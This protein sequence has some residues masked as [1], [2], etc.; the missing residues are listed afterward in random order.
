VRLS[1]T[2]LATL[3]AA[4]TTRPLAV[5]ATSPPDPQ[6]NPFGRY[7]TDP[8]GTLAGA[9]GRVLDVAAAAGHRLWLPLAAVLLAGVAGR[10]V[11][12]R[13]RAVRLRAGARLVEILP[14][15]QVDPAGAVACWRNLRGLLHQRRLLTGRPLVA[16][17]LRWTPDGLG[18]GIWVPGMLAPRLVE[19]AVQAAWPGARTRTHTPAPPPLPVTSGGRNVGGG[20]LRLAADEWY[21]LRTDHDRDPL[22]ALLG[23]AEELGAGEAS[24]VQILVR[25]ASGRR[26]AACRRAA[27]ALRR[28]QA[29]T[30][31]GRLLDFL[32]PLGNDIG[33]RRA[34][35]DDPA[36]HADVAAITAKSAEPGFE[37]AIRYAVSTCVDADWRGRLRARGH[38]LAA[39]LAVFADR[40]QLTRRRP[41]RPAVAVETRRLGRGM[42]LS[43]SELAALA[44]LPWDRAVP[45]LERAGARSVPPAPN[46]QRAGKVLGDADAGPA[47]PVALHP[48]DARQHVHVLGGTGTGKSTL[49]G[50]LI[51]QDVEAGRGVVVVDPA[52]GDLVRELLERLPA[53]AAGRLVLLDP[54]E[55]R[56]PPTLNMLQGADPDLATDH[57]LAVFRRVFASAWGPRTE[58]IL[59]AACLTLL[60]KGPASLVDVPRLLTK[61]DYR[62]HVTA[63]LDDELLEGFWG[64]YDRLPTGAHTQLVGPAL[65]RLR[66]FLLRPFVRDV[67]GSATSSFDLGEILDGGILLA[68]LPKGVLGEDTARL[69]GSFV[70]AQ[71]WQA[72]AR[73][74]RSGE[75][76][77]ADAALYVDEFHNVL[78]LPQTYE[79]LLAEARGYRLA[80]TLAH[81]NL[82]QLPRELREAMSANARSKVYFACSPEDAQ[83]LERHV[84]PELSAYDLSHL[85]GFQAAA[86]L[87]T[88]G[89]EAPACTLV[90]RPLPAPSPRR[91]ARL[92]AA[93]RA[94]Y[95]RTAA[96]RRA[97]TNRR[98]LHH[99]DPLPSGAGHRGDGEPGTGGP[100]TAAGLA[101]A[102]TPVGSSP[103]NWVGNSL[104]RLGPAG[105]AQAAAAGQHG[106]HA[107]ARGADSGTEPAS[108][109][110]RS[111]DG[112][113]GG[114]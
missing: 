88:G 10:V 9:A 26:L 90:T 83:V 60:A 93:A 37:V 44:H 104:G 29:P 57:L 113:R 102:G 62:A 65:S 87:V 67:V 1:R 34:Y 17:E 47:R 94:Q 53:S 25:R 74:A 99:Q 43:L 5:V 4:L 61:A 59:R 98:Q 66:A 79:E 81:Q 18:I 38:A 107:S 72:A 96:Q 12:G 35:T 108:S 86:R 68:R 51:L 31:R 110:P 42:L 6:D 7:L 101:E 14:P 24:I 100:G 28:G 21:S 48:A 56:A 58:D 50:N 76:A 106:A 73:R 32:N 114:R 15:P 27:R 55:R 46:L 109:P 112:E 103:G 95:G 30:R 54:D 11:L 69:L 91:A 97:E 3:L 23:A 40:N 84:A 89:V 78:H 22:R 20:R 85:G 13:W 105:G 33:S 2:L 92:R 63:R 70:V 52:K 71:T 80:L 16:F 82:A 39:A 19:R 36:R 41:W 77:R 111:P 8:W 75:H 64:E 45:G 49:L